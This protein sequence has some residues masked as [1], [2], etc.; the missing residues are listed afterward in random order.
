MCSVRGGQRE[1]R[2]A[3]PTVIALACFWGL[4]ACTAAN[5]EFVPQDDDAGDASRED[6]SEPP[7]DAAPM[8]ADRGTGGS[9]GG[10]PD[11]PPLDS[12]VP[13][14]PPDVA[15]VTDPALNTGLIGYWKFD[16]TSGTT[17]ADSSRSGHTGMLEDIDPAKGWVAGRRGGALKVTANPLSSGVRVAR[18]PAIDGIRKFTIAAWVFLNGG[19]TAYQTVLSRQV[20]NSEAEV[21]NVV[22][23]NQILTLYLPRVANRD[24][25]ARATVATPLSRWVH[26]AATFD[27]ATGRLY[28]D[29]VQVASTSY[30]GALV[31][32]T[33]P[34]YLGTNKNVTSMN[35]PL[36]GLMDDL[37]LYDTALSPALI[38][39]LATGVV[40]AP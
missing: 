4:L 14:G 7:R 38:A 22:F 17:A 23:V 26:V 28:S 10:K 20:D 34:I 32:A 31:A 19:N 24:Y 11:A 9:P 8:P 29:G 25:I 27:G 12:R 13:D 2:R 35:Q 33:T 40:P 6:Q 18:T 16:E 1:H 37:L 5:P 39:E 30:S 15:P 3:L 21:F 36:Q